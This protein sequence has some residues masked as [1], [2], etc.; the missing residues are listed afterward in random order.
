MWVSMHPDHPT[1]GVVD[2]VMASS[3]VKAD[4]GLGLRRSWIEN[5]RR[6]FEFKVTKKF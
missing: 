4:R 1:E 3:H 6:W 5:G 2:A